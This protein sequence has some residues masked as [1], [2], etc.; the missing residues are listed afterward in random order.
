MPARFCVT[1]RGTAA[2]FFN[3]VTFGK[4]GEFVEKYLTKGT[5]ILLTG[6]VQNDNY[7]NRN[8][9]KVYSVG[10]IADEIEFAE[11]KKAAAAQVPERETQPSSVGDG[12]M[13][14][15]DDV[16]DEELPFN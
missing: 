6:H 7:T 16:D 12:F 14:I 4:R 5:K 11:S 1:A 15:P 8:G 2:D 9:E 13:S 10:I 3:C